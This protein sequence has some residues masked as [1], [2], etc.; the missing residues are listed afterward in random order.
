VCPAVFSNDNRIK[1][2]IAFHLKNQ[3]S[4]DLRQLLRARATT[5]SENLAIETSLG[6]LPAVWHL[7]RLH[8]NVALE[9]GP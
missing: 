8:H 9:L 7:R 5:H 4:S 6:S 1:P 2:N 3:F